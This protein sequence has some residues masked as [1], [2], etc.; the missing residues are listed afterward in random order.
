MTETPLDLDLLWNAVRSGAECTHELLGLLGS[1]VTGVAYLAQ[2]RD[3]T[4]LQVLLVERRGA[5]L[6]FAIEP[7]DTLDASIPAPGVLCHSCQA[8]LGTWLPKCAACA[9]PLTTARAVEQG[10]TDEELVHAVA[11][12]W[13]ADIEHLGAMPLAHADGVVYFGR[14]RLN[15]A[16]V[17]ARPFRN[18]T[19]GVVLDLAPLEEGSGSSQPDHSTPQASETLVEMLCI[20]CQRR[21]PKGTEYCAS[22]GTLLRPVATPAGLVGR[23][24]AD[25]YRVI[26]L[27]GRGGMGE[28]YLA[29][30][31][32]MAREIALKVMRPALLH[33]TDAVVR[34]AAEAA[35]A[36]Q[37]VHPNVATVH[38]FGETPDG[39]VYLAMEY[40]PG[41]P[42]SAILARDGPLDAER[43]AALGVQIGAALAAAHERGLVHR[44][45]KPDNVMVMQSRR[46]GSAVAKVVDF[47][48][49]KAIR[50]AASTRAGQTLT[51]DGFVLGTPAYMSPEQ[52]RGEVLDPRTDVY[53]L[54]CILFELLTKQQV[55]AAESVERQI[56]RRLTEGA[57]QPRSTVPTVPDWL[58]AVVARALAPSRDERYQSAGALEA[59]LLEG[60]RGFAPLAPV[61][62]RVRAAKRWLVMVP[63]IL[64]CTVVGGVLV[65]RF[66]WGA[67]QRRATTTRPV[68]PPSVAPA[69]R[70]VVPLPI[71]AP[72]SAA[73]APTTN[74]TTANLPTTSTPRSGAAARPIPAPV[75]AERSRAS[76]GD[77]LA[78]GLE[79]TGLKANSPAHADTSPAVQRIAVPPPSALAPP[80]PP[81]SI[82]GSAPQTGGSPTA[83]AP[84]PTAV[85]ARPVR[86]AV[87]AYLAA[88]GQRD[89]A[90]VRRVYQG[91]SSTEQQG[92]KLLWSNASS[93]SVTVT[94]RGDLLIHDPRNAEETFGYIMTYHSPAEGDVSRPRRVKATLTKTADGWRIE[95]LAAP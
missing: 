42:L 13:P 66:P 34:F 20:T 49:A 32:R 75:N 31:V 33:E 82:G 64:L 8:P 48:I 19:G 94:E 28:V 51:R 57:P 47:G 62:P 44:D 59:A 53:S 63:A 6:E 84:E 60:P 40:V 24:I 7:R 58:N 36:S 30:Q 54:G 16:L 38:D 3:S 77:T 89:L 61:R 9:A 41:E 78:S 14:S 26:R 17:A 10:V 22:D 91:I 87:D 23:L 68:V 45:L 15:G 27:L 71:S 88:L 55:F 95:R 72:T 80:V 92:L 93:Y 52:L 5:E 29:E 69:G 18:A 21:Y 83:A 4:A 2:P 39:I 70:A 12:A 76:R 37:I 86:D 65:A 46:D 25:R 43:T 67:V 79:A 73:S 81:S 90:G 74:A 50:G 56:H 1:G 85:D 35:A 11:R